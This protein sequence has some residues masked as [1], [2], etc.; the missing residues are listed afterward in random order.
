MCSQIQTACVC[1]C[2]SGRH[3]KRL[4]LNLSLTLDLTGISFPSLLFVF[5]SSSLR[6]SFS[7]SLSIRGW[8][9]QEY[10][11]VFNFFI[12]LFPVLSPTLCCLSFSFPCL[13]LLPSFP[14]HL[15]PPYLPSLPLRSHVRLLVVYF[16][17]QKSLGEILYN[18]ELMLP[19]HICTNTQKQ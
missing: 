17:S 2:W 15:T 13:S 18:P 9:N 19:T 6:V 16:G 7:F 1:V 14:L 5:L 8:K 11:A 10:R 3:R 4:T 12:W